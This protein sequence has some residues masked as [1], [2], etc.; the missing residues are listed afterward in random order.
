MTISFISYAAAAAA[1]KLF[2]TVLITQYERP[3]VMCQNRKEEKNNN[4]LVNNRFL[5]PRIYF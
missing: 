3:K 2:V 5:F 4:K 1:A